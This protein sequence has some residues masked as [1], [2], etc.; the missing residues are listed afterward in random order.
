MTINSHE[1]KTRAPIYIYT[2]YIQYGIYKKYKKIY[3]FLL[4]KKSWKT[5]VVED[6]VAKVKHQ[7]F[8]WKKKPAIISPKQTGKPALRKTGLPRCLGSQG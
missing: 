5:G 4:Y 6:G 7:F 2:K 8:W 1:L 3:F